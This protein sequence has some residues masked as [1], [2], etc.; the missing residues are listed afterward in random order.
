VCV[1]VC[2]CVRVCVSTW[3]LFKFNQSIFHDFSSSYLRVCP[4][5][6]HA[7]ARVGVHIVWI[8]RT[9]VF[10]LLC[11]HYV[12]ICVFTLCA[13]L[14]EFKCCCVYTRAHICACIRIQVCARIYVIR[15]H[16]CTP[17]GVHT[18]RY[19]FSGKYVQKD[20]NML[21]NL[22]VEALSK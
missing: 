13:Y 21:A 5:W 20:L 7:C 12:H 9:F 15:T 4:H 1:C 19:Y 17:L 8:V 10:S 18:R 11:S 3:S 2:I 22:I 14:C 6:G 16:A